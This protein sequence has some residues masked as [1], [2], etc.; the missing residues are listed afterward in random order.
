MS[1]LLYTLAALRRR[2][3][4]IPGLRLLVRRHDSLHGGTILFHLARHPIDRASRWKIA[5]RLRATKFER[6]IPG[7]E[8]ELEAWDHVW[9][10][11]EWEIPTDDIACFADD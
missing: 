6:V 4:S 9:K 11:T 7:W 2:G 1:S 5:S 10:R 3:Q 8:R